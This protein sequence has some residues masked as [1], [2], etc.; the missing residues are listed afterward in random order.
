[1]ARDSVTEIKYIDSHTGGEPTRV[2]HSGAPEFGSGGMA[3]RLQVMKTEHDWL[4]LALILEP[5]GCDW[6]VGAV[7]QESCDATC[8]AGVIFFNN[9]GYLGMCG[10]GLIGVVE[11]L[12]H[13]GRIGAG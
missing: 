2:V 6:L 10:H 11:T 13:L 7:L 5:R 1:M 3:E 12:A 8:A 9:T 4:R